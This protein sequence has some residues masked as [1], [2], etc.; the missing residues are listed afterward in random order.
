MPT[1]EE[2]K[3]PLSY[4]LKPESFFSYR[5]LESKS[6]VRKLES[7]EAQF[8]KH[9][10]EGEIKVNNTEVENL[11]FFQIILPSK[12]KA[13][14]SYFWHPDQLKGFTKNAIR[15]FKQSLNG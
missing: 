12:G 13:L 3:K 7:I 2:E 1:K 15:A 10:G 5:D 4:S 6:L 14:G 8:I 11:T 9:F